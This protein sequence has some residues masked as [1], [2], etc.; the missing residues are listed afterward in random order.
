MATL[1]ADDGSTVLTADD[2]VTPLTDGEAIFAKSSF[3]L[4]SFPGF[5]M[6]SYSA[7]MVKANIVFRMEV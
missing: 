4:K 5:S 3:E 2:G 1:T 7:I 6:K